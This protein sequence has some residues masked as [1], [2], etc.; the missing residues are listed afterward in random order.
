MKKS[1][2]VLST[3][4]AIV[5]TA[6]MSFSMT[7]S[8]LAAAGNCP[9]GSLKNTYNSSPAEC[10]V[11]GTDTFA[12]DFKNIINWI[13]GVAGLVAVVVVIIGGVTYMTSNGDPGKVKKG[14]DTILY[15]IIGLLICALAFAIVNF[16]IN[17]LF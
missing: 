10:N 1:K 12:T 17:G 5:A 16:V 3:A 8:V 7:G 14:K 15:G 4:L 11:D 9:A 6:I 13:V 2:A